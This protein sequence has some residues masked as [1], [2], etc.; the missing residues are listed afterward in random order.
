M[1]IEPNFCK[2]GHYIA[3]HPFPGCPEE[4]E[5]IIEQF[6]RENP[7]AWAEAVREMD[8][9]LKGK[10]LVKRPRILANPFTESCACGST[11]PERCAEHCEK[12]EL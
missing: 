2:C 7:E 9:Y 10:G 1:M 6:K 5:T 3:P 8:E 11:I 4:Q 12:D